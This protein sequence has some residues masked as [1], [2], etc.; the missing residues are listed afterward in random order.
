MAQRATASGARL[1]EILDREPRIVG[2]AAALPPG[3]GR[4]EL[5]D[6]TFGYGSGPDALR[7]VVAGRR[8]GL[9]RRAR[10]RDRLGQ[11]DARPAAAAAL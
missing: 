11:D 5:R 3:R 4:V 9:D 6:V 7:D 2:G 8:A 1:F 10:R